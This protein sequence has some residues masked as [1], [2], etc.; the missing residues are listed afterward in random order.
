[1]IT[2]LPSMCEALEPVMKR[3][4]KERK[5]ERKKGRKE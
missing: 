1:M 3:K 4:Q 5:G 2:L